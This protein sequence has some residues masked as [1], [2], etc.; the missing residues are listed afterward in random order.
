MPLTLKIA[1]PLHPK[2]AGSQT[3]IS[4]GNFAVSKKSSGGDLTGAE[5]NRKDGGEVKGAPKASIPTTA[6]YALQTS[7]R[8]NKP[9]DGI[10]AIQGGLQIVPGQVSESGDGSFAAGALTRIFPAKP[11][12]SWDQQNS[13]PPDQE[14]PKGP[15]L[16]DQPWWYPMPP[17]C[18]WDQNDTY[19][20]STPGSSAPALLAGPNLRI[21]RL[22]IE[23]P[24]YEVYWY[25]AISTEFASNPANYL[26]KFQLLWNP[27]CTADNV[28]LGK[29]LED[30]WA[31]AGFERTLCYQ[32]GG[33]TIVQAQ[34][35]SHWGPPLPSSD[36]GSNWEIFTS[37]GNFPLFAF[38]GVDQVAIYIPPAS[39]WI[40]PERISVP[41]E[42]GGWFSPSNSKGVC[43]VPY[44]EDG[45]FQI[46]IPMDDEEPIYIHH[47]VARRPQS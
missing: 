1:N 35:T 25:G 9:E 17:M 38:L 3:G 8:G 46:K 11:A 39:N 19:S 10:R 47:V 40:P 29:D 22:P 26:G 36:D 21:Y 7:A 27:Q 13:Q 14:I 30:G 4:G 42:D 12:E 2:K 23:N 5:Q 32:G 37:T 24:Q 18:S 20:H 33:D 34:G 28:L 41:R 16:G 43:G 45:V 44:C 15:Y 6:K 31:A